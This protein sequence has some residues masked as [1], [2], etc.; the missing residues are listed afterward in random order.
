MDPDFDRPSSKKTANSRRFP[1]R[2]VG[3]LMVLVALV[4]LAF[5]SMAQCGTRPQPAL[6]PARVSLHHAY[7][8]SGL[9]LYQGFY[10]QTPMPVPANPSNFIV[11]APRGI[12]ERFIVTAPSGIDD[13]IL[14]SPNRLQKTIDKSPVPLWVAPLVP[15]R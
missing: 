9:D 15:A 10:G 11:P 13:R 1:F 6:K 7:P 14:V 8:G 5:T 2:N 12:D 3:R 4:S